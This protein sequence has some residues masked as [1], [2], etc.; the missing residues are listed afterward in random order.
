L[1][2]VSSRRISEKEIQMHAWQWVKDAYPDLLIFHVPSGE[3]RDM[4]T[5]MKLKRMG[6]V[7]GVAD[8]LM[9]L[10][11]VPIAIELK[12]GKGVQSGAQEHFQKVWERLGHVYKIAR[13]LDEF[14]TIVET[15]YWP[16]RGWP[17][18]NNQ[19]P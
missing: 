7:P 11:G 10:P 17:P 14:K 1:P 16:W 18:S 19:N 12:T 9:F 6:V 15:Y 8:F 3:T 13:S 4:A 2:K 5:A